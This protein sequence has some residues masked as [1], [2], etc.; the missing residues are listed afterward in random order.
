MFPA[1]SSAQVFEAELVLK[2]QASRLLQTFFL[3]LHSFVLLIV[4]FMPL[5]WAWKLLLML[6]I[7]A[8]GVYEWRS[9]VSLGNCAFSQLIWRESGAWELV[10][11]AG[12]HQGSS[13]I[14]QFSSTLIT[15]LH[16]KVQHK[17]LVVIFLPD[18]L[19]ADAQQI[20]RRRLKLLA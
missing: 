17:T 5:T 14:Q 16:L 4:L 10:T 7:T 11:A 12:K 13:L 3:L 2:L 1:L 20:L 6:G 9:Q 19:A 8:L 15:I 18:N